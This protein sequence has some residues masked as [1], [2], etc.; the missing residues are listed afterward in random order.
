M[1]QNE[2]F[3]PRGAGDACVLAVVVRLWVCLCV[4]VCV[5]VS[6]TRRYCITSSSAVADKPAR[7]PASRQTQYFKTVT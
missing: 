7:R 1:A 3:Y 6:V 2:N 4:C 5:C